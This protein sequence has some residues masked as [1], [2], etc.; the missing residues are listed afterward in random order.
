MRV[1]HPAGAWYAPCLAQGQ[2]RWRHAPPPEIFNR[3]SLARTISV[4]DDGIGIVE[5][6]VAMLEDEGYRVL[7]AADGEGAR[8][9]SGRAAQALNRHAHRTRI[10]AVRDARRKG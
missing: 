7:R 8:A 1:S 9:P 6:R 10:C 3:G 4:A 5:M 2:T